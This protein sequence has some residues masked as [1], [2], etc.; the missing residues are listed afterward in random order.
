M[1]TKPF[2]VNFPTRLGEFSPIE[3]LF[4]LGSSLKMTEVARIYGL[5]FTNVSATY[6]LILTKMGWNRY[7][8]GYF[9]KNSSGHPATFIHM[10]VC[11]VSPIRTNVPVY[12]SGV[13]GIIHDISPAFERGHLEE[14]QVGPTHVVKVDPGVGPVEVVVQAGRLVVHDRGIQDVAVKVGA[15]NSKRAIL[16]PLTTVLDRMLLLLWTLAARFFWVQ[17][18]KT[19]K[20]YRITT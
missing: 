8:F 15:L 20:M 11:N 3:W 16:E 4:T 18:T 14:G 12:L 17:H 6:L 5:L 10:Y 9:F 19:G 7:I 2:L 13:N 1:Y